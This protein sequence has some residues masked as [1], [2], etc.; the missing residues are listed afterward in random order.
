MSTVK[1]TF[2]GFVG[3]NGVPVLLADG[4]EYDS[5]HPLVEAHPEMFTEPP[6]RRQVKQQQAAPKRASDG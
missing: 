2:D 6:A 1:A 3:L 5:E 4:D